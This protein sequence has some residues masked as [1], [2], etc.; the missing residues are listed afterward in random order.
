MA[1]GAALQGTG[2]FETAGQ[3]RPLRPRKLCVRIRIEIKAS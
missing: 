1:A 3:S 2:S